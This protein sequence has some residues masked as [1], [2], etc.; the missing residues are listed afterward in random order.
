[1]S[2]L[3]AMRRALDDYRSVRPEADLQALAQ[4]DRVA[5]SGQGAA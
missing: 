3:F 2:A 4:R 1:V 5:A